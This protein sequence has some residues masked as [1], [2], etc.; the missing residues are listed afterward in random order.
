MV[1]EITENIFWTRKDYNPEVTFWVLN[2]KHIFQINPVWGRFLYTNENNFRACSRMLSSLSQTTKF[3]SKNPKNREKCQRYS[4]IN[5]QIYGKF[6]IFQKFPAF[7]SIC[8]AIEER[9]K[10]W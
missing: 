7:N 3:S 5:K 10:E 6:R 8:I 1:P 4:D 2:A 9:G